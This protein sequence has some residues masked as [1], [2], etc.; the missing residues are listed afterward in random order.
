MFKHETQENLYARLNS[1]ELSIPDEITELTNIVNL[2]LAL[3]SFSGK[4]PE[5]VGN[6]DKLGELLL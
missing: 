6:L 3:N 4:I 5:A 1:F 2:D